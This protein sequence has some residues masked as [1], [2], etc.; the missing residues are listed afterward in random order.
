MKKL[1]ESNWPHHLYE[2]QFFR[3]LVENTD[4]LEWLNERFGL[5]LLKNSYSA[6]TAS[7]P[8]MEDVY[9]A[10]ENRL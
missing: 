7:N 4:R 2:K 6:Q 3:P 8:V 5:W 1:N 9:P 10:R